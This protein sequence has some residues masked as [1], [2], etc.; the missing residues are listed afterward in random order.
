MKLRFKN[1]FPETDVP[2]PSSITYTP[3]PSIRHDK[4]EM[5]KL[6]ED[7]PNFVIDGEHWCLPLKNKQPK[8]LTWLEKLVPK[9]SNCSSPNPA[10]P[11]KRVLEP[12]PINTMSPEVTK[13]TKR[14]KIDPENPDL[15]SPFSP[16]NRTPRSRKPS[17]SKSASLTTPSST[18]KTPTSRRSTP[19]RFKQSLTSDTCPSP[20]ILQFFAVVTHPGDPGQKPM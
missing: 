6:L 8:K 14:V 15:K 4:E 2:A 18:I 1:Q 9:V 7:M 13:K 17:I 16:A 12:S 19:R 20:K 5:A 10:K 11:E 3:L